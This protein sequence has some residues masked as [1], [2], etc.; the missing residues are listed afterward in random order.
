MWVCHGTPGTPRDDTPGYGVPNLNSVAK[1]SFTS[2]TRSWSCLE[3]KTITI[4]KKQRKTKLF[5]ATGFEF[6]YAITAFYFSGYNLGFCY[7]IV[8]ILP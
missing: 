2:R 3:A 7:F 5:L 4:N 6:V 8:D 1:K